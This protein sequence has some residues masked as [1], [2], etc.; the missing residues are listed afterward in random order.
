MLTVAEAQRIAEEALSQPD[1]R[2]LV[3][4]T[5]ERPYGWVFFYP[6]KDFLESGNVL[7]M[8]LGNAPLLVLRETGEVRTLGTA[9]PVEVFLERV[10]EELGA[11]AHPEN[12][13]QGEEAGAPLLG[14]A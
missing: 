4:D 12:A 3:E 8:L 10:D 9:H 1:Y 14:R 13:L 11:Q 7:D 2:I 5:M 6:S